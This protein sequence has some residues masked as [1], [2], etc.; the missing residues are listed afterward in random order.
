MLTVSSEK[1]YQTS[2]K[3]TEQQA[4]DMIAAV[5]KLLGVLMISTNKLRKAMREIASKKDDLLFL[6]SSC[7][8]MHWVAG[9]WLSRPCGC[10]NTG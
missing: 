3:F 2:G 5:T 7:G 9:T 10:K 8:L 1:R 6:E 4:K